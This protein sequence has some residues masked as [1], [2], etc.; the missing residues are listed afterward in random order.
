MK[1]K[2]NGKTFDVYDYDDDLT[3]LERYSASIADTLPSFFRVKSKDFALEKDADIQVEDI[4]EILV[5]MDVRDVSNLD[6]IQEIT[7]KFPRIKK[8]EIGLLWL[9]KHPKILDNAKSDVSFLKFL[10]KSAFLSIFKAKSSVNDYKKEMTRLNKSYAAAAAVENK[11]LGELSAIKSVP[12]EKFHLEEASVQNGIVLSENIMDVFDAFVCSKEIPFLY[13]IRKS[14]RF[15]KVYTQ[16]IPPDSWI[17]ESLKDDK[18]EGIYFKILNMPQSKLSSKILLENLYA[19]AFWSLDNMLYFTYKIREGNSEQIIRKKITDSIGDRIDYKIVSTQQIGVKGT[20]EVKKINIERYIFADLVSTNPLFKRFLYLDERGTSK[21]GVP[22]TA[23]TKTRLFVHYT[24]SKKEGFGVRSLG[25]TITPKQGTLDT[26]SIRVSGAQNYQQAN[27]VG[28]T[29]SKLLGLYKSKHDEIKELYR[30]IIPNLVIEEQ[31]LVGDDKEKGDETVASKPSKAAPSKTVKTDKRAGVRAGLLREKSGSTDT[32]GMFKTRYPD[33]CQREK[34]PVILTEE[35]ANAVAEKLGDPHKVMFFEGFWYGCDPREPD[36]KNFKH[37]WP[38]LKEN[39]SKD[40]EYAKEFP[41]LPC[42]YTKDQYTKNASQL[43]LYM[44][45]KGAPREIKKKE[46]GIDYIVRS[47]KLAQVGRF[48]EMPYNWEKIFKYIGLEKIQKGPHEK[49][50]AF[51]PVLRYG[52]EESPGSIVHCME[53]IFN[54]QY[55]KM[56]AVQRKERVAEVRLELSNEDFEITKQETFDYTKKE[57]QELLQDP[58]VYLEPELFVSLLQKHYDCN[59]FMYVKDEAHPNGD[60]AI[61]RYSQAFL[62]RDLD[63]TKPNVLI[64]KYEAH[65]RDYPYQCEIISSA[66]TEGGKIKGAELI[67]KKSSKIT[68]MAMNMFYNANEIF[69]V[70]P[71]GYVPYKPVPETL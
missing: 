67:F 71:E 66:K 69:I 62:S 46:S 32:K 10:D 8:R 64:F 14:R 68:Q 34:Q 16:M 30:N 40:V 3:V 58:D 29:F 37:L 41:L 24:S 57:L 45:E 42:C 39:K 60:V 53:R 9:M 47:D 65:G 5:K 25:I 35:E 59:I 33:Q 54:P 70:N 7:A 22:L 21:K 63:D 20:F 61:P 6:K 19:N 13:M 17:E 15:Y 28:N 18:S 55:K 36:E 52:V 51:Y 56:N 23:M 50:K 38:G 31:H 12:V 11:L 27:A 2:I 4:R 26:L 49:D 48:G 1:I 43:R 44:Q